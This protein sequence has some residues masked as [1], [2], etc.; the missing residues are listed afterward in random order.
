MTD[1]IMNPPAPSG[2]RDDS[3]LTSEG[4]RFSLPANTR[5]YVDSGGA[6][7]FI[8][9]DGTSRYVPPGEVGN[10]YI[11]GEDPQSALRRHLVQ[12]LPY[13][14]A[15]RVNG[16][17]DDLFGTMDE[18]RK[19]GAAFK[20]VPL[21]EDNKAL[22]EVLDRAYSGKDVQQYPKAKYHQNGSYRAVS[23]DEEGDLGDGWHDHPDD[24][25]KAAR[26]AKREDDDDR[27]DPRMD[28]EDNLKSSDDL[29]REDEDRRA[30]EYRNKPQN[31]AFVG[32]GGF[33]DTGGVI[34]PDVA[35]GD[36]PAPVA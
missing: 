33:S 10:F 1:P 22:A 32:E 7:H 19:A 13:A 5:M 16:M 31:D 14:D 3:S 8:L 35:K 36:K 23:E 17:L 18:L 30:S 12:E 34:K 21:N 29:K 2:R 25:K 4:E 9:P 28:V 27:Y 20:L 24:A 26:A 6:K 11:E 15:A